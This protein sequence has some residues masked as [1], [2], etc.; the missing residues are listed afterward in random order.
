MGLDTTTQDLWRK[1]CHD[2]QAEGFVHQLI[3]ESHAVT[4]D[5]DTVVRFRRD[6]DGWTRVEPGRAPPDNAVSDQA[7]KDGAKEVFVTPQGYTR[8]PESM[9]H[10]LGLSEKGA[11]VWFLRG[12]DTWE[13]WPEAMLEAMLAEKPE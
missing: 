11:H 10:E 7:K 4:F 6:A 8:L 3:F 13:A 9:R 2:Q 1:V 5:N 12:P